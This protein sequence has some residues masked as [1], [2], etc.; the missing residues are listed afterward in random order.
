MHFSGPVEKEA[1]PQKMTGTATSGYPVQM[2]LGFTAVFPR[3]PST[4]S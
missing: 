2:W 4:V 1:P 3:F